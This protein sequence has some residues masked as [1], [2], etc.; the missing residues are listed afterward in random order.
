MQNDYL[1]L[2][3]SVELSGD[4]VKYC[5]G[6]AQDLESFKS[7]KHPAFAVLA[8]QKAMQAAKD[9]RCVAISRPAAERSMDLAQ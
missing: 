3:T 1:G 2:D 6:P 5:I 9:A 7:R 4:N 8:R